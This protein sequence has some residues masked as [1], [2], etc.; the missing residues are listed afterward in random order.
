MSHIAGTVEFQ[1]SLLLF[2]ALGGYLI[3]AAIIDDVLALLALAVA[4]QGA[5]AAV[6]P[7]QIVWLAVEGAAFLTVGALGGKF[8]ITRLIDRIDASARLQ[9]NAAYCFASITVAVPLALF[10][11]TVWRLPLTL[12]AT[13]PETAY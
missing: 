6:E 1:M 4:Q 9:S 10:A 7:I 13:S 2:V 8:V 5:A 11:L 3:A 12:T